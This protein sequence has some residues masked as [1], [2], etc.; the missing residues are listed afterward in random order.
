MNEPQRTFLLDLTRE[1]LLDLI[2]KDKRFAEIGVAEGTFSREILARARP[3]SLLL[4]DPWR[5]QPDFDYGRDI[6]NAG[7]G[8]QDARFLAVCREFDRP[9]VTVLRATSQDAARHLGDGDVDYLYLDARHTLDD[10]TADLEAWWPKLAPDGLLMGH[11]YANHSEARK[12]GFAV[13]EAVNA[14]VARKGCPFVGITHE[15]YPSF[16]LA[17]SWHAGA[18]AILL[19]SRILCSFEPIRFDFEVLVF[20]DGRYR[21]FPKL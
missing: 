18:S 13:V 6:S 17:K 8:D 5:H 2:D 20:S 15:L 12:L 16:V 14:F 19:K 1:G 3:S 4:I 9:G 21:A 10:V 7:Q 11:D